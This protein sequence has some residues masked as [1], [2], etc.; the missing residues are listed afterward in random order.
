M[1]MSRIWSRVFSLL[2]ALV[3]HLVERVL[4]TFDREPFYRRIFVLTPQP[5]RGVPP[6][7]P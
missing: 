5:S 3:P 4:Q 2:L 6:R 7:C 1:E